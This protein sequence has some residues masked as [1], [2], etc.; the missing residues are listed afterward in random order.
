MSHRNNKTRWNSWYNMLDWV[1]NKI[2]PSIVAVTNGNFHLAQ[3]GLTV[4]DL[5]NSW[6]Y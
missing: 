6:P 5:E 1:I 3:D 4:Q 2:K